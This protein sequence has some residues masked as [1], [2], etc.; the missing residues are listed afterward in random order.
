MLHHRLMCDKPK[1]MVELMTVA[2]QYT[3]ADAT[4]KKPLRVNAD[5][6]PTP[7]EPARDRPSNPAGEAGSSRCHGNDNRFHEDRQARQQKPR[8][9]AR[10]VNAVEGAPDA[11]A[12]EARRQKP[13]L[14]FD[15]MIDGPC[16][17]HS[18]PFK[19]ATHTT[20]NCSWTRQL[21]D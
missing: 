18:G 8:Y 13:W 19:P 20:R 1:T 12:N 17:W 21:K 5:G 11:P 14:T 10:Q 6:R 9:H 15:Q 2:D 16:K 7:S 3:T 4:M